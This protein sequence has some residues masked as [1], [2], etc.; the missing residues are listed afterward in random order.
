MKLSFVI[1]AYNE[2]KYVGRCLD[3]ILKELRDSDYD[4]E[5]IV[6]DNASTD[7]TRLAAE[8]YPGV[9][10]VYEPNK[11]LV[12]ARRAGFLAANGDLIANVDADTVLTKNWVK[13]VIYEFSKNPKLV[14]LSGP[15]IYY[16]LPKS[17]D[18]FARVIFYP[19]GL[20]TNFI[21]HIIF[22]RGTMLQGGNFIL[23]KDALVKIGGYNTE[24]NF[25]GEDTDIAQRIGKVGRVKF[26]YRLPIYASGRRLAK[27]GFFTMAA[28]YSLNYF[29]MILFKEPLSKTSIDIRDTPSQNFKEYKPINKRKEI[30]MAI[31]VLSIV[32]TIIFGIGY[33]GYKLIIKSGAVISL[34]ENKE[35]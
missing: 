4:A 30:V 26:T 12:R 22:R 24:I 7:G 6:V 3:S 13:K 23:R 34:I 16:D 1:P 17:V 25:Y 10:V 2:E 18:I 31:I 27:E 5:I 32:F 8:K 19:L 28:R 11:G 29:S 20:L 35:K 15:F 9:K 21:N 33:A 14:A